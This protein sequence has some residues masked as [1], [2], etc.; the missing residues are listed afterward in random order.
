MAEPNTIEE[1]FDAIRTMLDALKP[2]N[3]A[4]V[5]RVCRYVAQRVEQQ[6][7]GVQCETSGLAQAINGGGLTAGM[8]SNL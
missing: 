5:D 2:L 3:H 1:E 8:R 7:Y 4:A 6:R